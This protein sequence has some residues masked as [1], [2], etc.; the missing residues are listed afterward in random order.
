MKKRKLSQIYAKSNSEFNFGLNKQWDEADEVQHDAL[1]SGI[2]LHNVMLYRNYSDGWSAVMNA[3][4]LVETS[5]GSTLS[6][7]I[8][9]D[10]FSIQLLPEAEVLSIM[11]NTVPCEQRI[12]WYHCTTRSAFRSLLSRR[13]VDTT[14]MNVLMASS[15]KCSI[16]RQQD[17]SLLAT[18]VSLFLHKSNRINLSQVYMY[19]V[20]DAIITYEAV[21]SAH[22]VQGSDSVNCGQGSMQ[23]SMSRR[24]AFGHMS[25]RECSDGMMSRKSWRGPAAARMVTYGVVDT[26]QALGQG[27]N[28]EV[29]GEGEETSRHECK[30]SYD[31]NCSPCGEHEGELN[32]TEGRPG[33]TQKLMWQPNGKKWRSSSAQGGREEEDRPPDMNNLR[34]FIEERTQFFNLM[35][36]N[37]QSPRTRQELLTHGPGFFLHEAAVV[38]LSMAVSVTNLYSQQQCTLSKI[39]R[40]D[41]AVDDDVL[42]D[43]ESL[44]AGLDLIFNIIERLTVCIQ[45]NSSIFVA[46]GPAAYQLE[47]CQDFAHMLSSVTLLDKELARMKNKLVDLACKRHVQLSVALSMT[48]SLF[49]PLTFIAGIFGMNFS[50]SYGDPIT[51]VLRSSHADTI[52][53]TLSFL[54]LMLS[55]VVVYVKG[56][57]D[58]LGE[59]HVAGRVTSTLTWW[60]RLWGNP[61]ALFLS[62]EEVGKLLKERRAT[63]AVMITSRRQRR[64]A[65]IRP[66]I[67][68]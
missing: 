4:P 47:L 30:G 28:G 7:L 53:W 18:L 66:K 42:L 5:L 38:M 13:S 45:R 17:G 60:K 1:T 56:W 61:D 24:E 23:G 46:L 63:G 34:C 55:L 41:N 50:R 31:T 29:D 54:V 8:T 43:I 67:Q 59:L 35:M 14:A 26:C 25:N 19:I 36:L 27:G 9:Q 22:V 52:F 2:L 32:T 65:Q 12:A 3:K 62:K 44:R 64:H 40:T 58:A 15:P 49:W 68:H 10:E 57:G 48:A 11:E 51:Q 16:L 20:D 21:T 33:V 6:C 39:L 37:L